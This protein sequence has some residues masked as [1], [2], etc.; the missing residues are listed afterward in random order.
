M[1]SL[2][3][4]TAAGSTATAYEFHAAL[5]GSDIKSS[6]KAGENRGRVLPHDFAVLADANVA[7][8]MN[9]SMFQGT[10]T[11]DSKPLASTNRLALAAWVTARTSLQPVQSVGGWLPAGMAGALPR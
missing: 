9:D 2:N 8:K 3:R 1:F 4:C 5:L 6:V 7:A 10:V 11:F